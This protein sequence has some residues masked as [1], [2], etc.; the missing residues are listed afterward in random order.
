MLAFSSS[1]DVMMTKLN[2]IQ[3]GLAG[4]TELSKKYELKR[5]AEWIR[6]HNF[7]RVSF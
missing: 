4:F 1:D 5:C 6:D 3:Q 7:V 2:V